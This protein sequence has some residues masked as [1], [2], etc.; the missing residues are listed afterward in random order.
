MIVAEKKPIEEIIAETEPFGN[1]LILGC[2]ECVTVCEAGGKKEVAVSG[3]C[4]KDVLF[5]AGPRCPRRRDHPGTPVRSRISGRDPG[6][7]GPVRRHGLHRLRCRGAVHRRRLPQ[8]AGLSRCQHLLHGRHRRTG[9]LDRALPGMRQCIL[10]STGGICPVSR[11]A[12]RLLNGPC[13][14]ASNGKCEISKESTLRLAIDY[15]L[16]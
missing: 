15:R 12:K 6:Q 4:P 16:A 13:G 11:C 3:L 5:Q 1:I 14:G 8:H 10:A 9:G 2:N 7:H